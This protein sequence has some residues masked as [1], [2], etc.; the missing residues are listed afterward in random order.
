MSRL[1][2]DLF[3]LRYLYS[4]R[5]AAMAIVGYVNHRNPNVAL[6]A[7]SVRRQA[8]PFSQ[9][10]VDLLRSSSYLTYA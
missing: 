6:L 1:L 2:A 8:L 9:E 3:L 10:N 7:L 4:P 5:E